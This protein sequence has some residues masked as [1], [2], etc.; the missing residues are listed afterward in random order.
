FGHCDAS[1]CGL[2]EFTPRPDYG[3]A[4][5]PG[6]AAARAEDAKAAAA[7]YVAAAPDRRDAG[8]RPLGTAAD[9]AK[10]SVRRSKRDVGGGTGNA[11]AIDEKDAGEEVL[12]NR[13]LRVCDTEPRDTAVCDE[14]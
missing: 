13:R 11:A 14:Q 4:S 9:A 3:K 8:P 12:R 1:C 5:S 2:V 7:T 6:R 10:G